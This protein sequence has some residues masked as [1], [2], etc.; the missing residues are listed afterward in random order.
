[1][2]RMVER[3]KTVWLLGAGFSRALGG[4]LFTDLISIPTARWVSAWVGMHGG[5]NLKSREYTFDDCVKIYV[6]GV[7]SGLWKNAEDCI[8][9]LDRAQKESMVATVINSAFGGEQVGVPDNLKLHVSEK[10]P[11][12]LDDVFARFTQFLAIATSHYVPDSDDLPEA[13]RPFENWMDT[14]GPDDTII[15]FNYDLVVETL[16]RIK[17]R[18]CKV[19]KLHGTTPEPEALMELV[20]ENRPVR[21][22]CVPGP[23]KLAA[24]RDELEPYWKTAELALR[25]AQRLVVI[26]Y[27]FPVSDALSLDFVL[28]HSEAVRVD[29]VLG[30][31]TPENP[32]GAR[33]CGYFTHL[34]DKVAD[35]NRYAQTY[36][37]EGTARSRDGKFMHW[38]KLSPPDDENPEPKRVSVF[39]AA[40]AFRDPPKRGS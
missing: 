20:R 1:M 29:I 12:R 10:L 38:S 36:F 25:E 11:L 28:R 30:P 26:G 16:K 33:V 4:P 34:R 2:R 9:L 32:D 13:W 31:D 35:M 7:N 5:L 24:S 15:S 17:N 27:S 40:D 39:D 21:S 14:L 23:S 37:T 6:Q 3:A 22:I 19:I 18:A 8:T